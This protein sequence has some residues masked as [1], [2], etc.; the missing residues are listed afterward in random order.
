[1]PLNLNAGPNILT[2]RR[3]HPDWEWRA[4]HHGMGWRY[5]GTREGQRVV[6]QAEGVICGP[7]EDDVDTR[8]VCDD[9]TTRQ[10]YAFWWFHHSRCIPPPC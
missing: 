10:S 1:M 4:E 5:V 3:D 7:A 6:V 2:L 8:W 9:G